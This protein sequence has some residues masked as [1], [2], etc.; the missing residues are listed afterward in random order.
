MAKAKM[1]LLTSEAPFDGLYGS[2]WEVLDQSRASFFRRKPPK[3]CKGNI[4]NPVKYAL[5]RYGRKYF[6]NASNIFKE[7]EGGTVDRDA[8]KN[9]LYTRI[10]I[11]LFR[12]CNMG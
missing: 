3:S 9:R 2:S 1:I 12:Q 5:L 6:K 8:V 4:G 7:H 10:T 11:C